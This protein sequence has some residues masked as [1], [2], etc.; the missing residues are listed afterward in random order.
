MVVETN[1]MADT[2]RQEV[3]ISILETPRP[4]HSP[5][6]PND[7]G[8]IL[9]KQLSLSRKLDEVMTERCRYLCDRLGQ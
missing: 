1:T 3:I 9:R 8:A 5:K 2:L 7:A 4:T 6:P